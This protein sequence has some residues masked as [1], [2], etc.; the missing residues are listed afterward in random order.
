MFDR[1]FLA[2]ILHRHDD[3]DDILKRILDDGDF[4]TVFT[5]LIA[6]EVYRRRADPG[7]W[8]GDDRERPP[9]AQGTSARR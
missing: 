9:V 7:E 3:N 4:R 5:A 6:D 1:E 8:G 2:T